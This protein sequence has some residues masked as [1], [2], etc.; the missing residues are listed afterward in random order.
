MN[1]K[2]LPITNDPFAL[3]YGKGLTRAIETFAPLR[4]NEICPAAFTLD[5]NRQ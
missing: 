5:G 4:V 2:R 1:N 3:S